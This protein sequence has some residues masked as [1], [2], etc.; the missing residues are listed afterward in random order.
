M[1]KIIMQLEPLAC[2][3]CMQKI[4]TALKAQPGVENIK[5]LFNASKAKANFDPEVT[6]EQHLK[7]AI[8]RIGYNV[9]D[10]KVK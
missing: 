7:E 2:P 9:L 5:V 8:N 6:D 3:T 1:K 10:I 4:E